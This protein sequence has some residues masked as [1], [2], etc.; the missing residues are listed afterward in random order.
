MKKIVIIFILLTNLIYAFDMPIK[1]F[2]TGNDSVGE[3]LV[4][5][6][7]ENITKSPFMHIAKD[8]EIAIEIV[9]ITLDSDKKNSGYST[10]YSITWT[11]SSN[12][13][14]VAYYLSSNVGYSGTDRI[15]EVA[16]LLTA[17]TYQEAQT[18]ISIIEKNQT[19]K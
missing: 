2:H 6:L 14:L 18:L 1:I 7:K 17:L 11:T 15:R 9:I 4:Y 12:G 13:G 16:E 3:R 8:K 5:F 19:K 10:V